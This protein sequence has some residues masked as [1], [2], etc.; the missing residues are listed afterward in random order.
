MDPRQGAVEMRQSA[1]Q[2]WSNFSG[3]RCIELGPVLSMRQGI[4][5]VSKIKRI[6]Y[7]N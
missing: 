2:D 5:T 7:R 3:E 6:K 1:L 4:K